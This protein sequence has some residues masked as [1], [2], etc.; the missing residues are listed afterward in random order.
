MMI[1]LHPRLL[2]SLWLSCLL[3]LLL[4]SRFSNNLR[5]SCTA[6]TEEKRGPIL[7]NFIS[8]ECY[9]DLHML[10]GDNLEKTDFLKV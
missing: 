6:E 3:L 8:N 2:S 7:K 5:I 9:Y 10:I 4:L 1:I